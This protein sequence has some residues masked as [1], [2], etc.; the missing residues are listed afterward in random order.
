M[1][2]TKLGKVFK[3]RKGRVGSYKYVNGKRVGFVGSRKKKSKY[4]YKSDRKFS[5]S[6][7]RARARYQR[8]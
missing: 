6:D 1:A 2:R 8:R 4:A 7:A 5:H 3:T